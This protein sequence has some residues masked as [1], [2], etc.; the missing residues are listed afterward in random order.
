[1]N[2]KGQSF[3]A[4]AATLMAS[5]LVVKIIGMLFKIPLT[6]MLGGEGMGYYMTAYSIF[7]PIYAL[8]VA[9]FPVAVS[10]L[11]ASSLARHRNDEPHR[12]LTVALFLFLPIGLG[13]AAAIYFAAPLFVKIVGNEAAIA[14]VRSIA[15]AVF[16]CCIS[17]VFRGYY[18]GSRNMVPTAVS[19]VV[20]ASVKLGAGIFCA[21]RTLRV[22]LAHFAAG[23][24]VCG[25]IV[26]SLQDAQTVIAPYAAAAAISGVTIST[27]A[28]SAVLALCY[29]GEPQG[30]AT[31]MVEHSAPH[32]AK[33][34]LVT[35]LPVCAGAL[36]VNLSSLIDLMSV[37]N[38]L[39]LAVVRGWETICLS[40]P[41]AGLEGMEAERIGNFLFG[42]YSGLAMTIF[43]LVPAL[44]ASFGVCALPLIASLA[45]RGNR[46]A[47]RRTV[48]SVLRITVLVALP[49]GFG[50]SCMAGPILELLFSSNPE[51]ISVA[52]G[53]LRP[54]G[55]AA[56]FVAISGCVNSML[57]ALG[58]VMVPVRLMLCGAAVKLAVNWVLI[59]QPGI[60]ISGAPWGT[61]CCYLLMALMGCSALERA[62]EGQ[63]NLV[64]IFAK[65]L[66][67]TLL[68][69]ATALMTR[70]FLAFLDPRLCTLLAAAAAG[71]CYLAA[72]LL[73]GALREEDM[74]LLPKGIKIR[75]ER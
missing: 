33:S 18:E 2:R 53:L 66:L 63:L 44:T 30:K 51:E 38:R 17:A 9:G 47:L 73:L 36:V 31:Q 26:T 34:L 54:L 75:K 52:V 8:C 23:E 62:T 61:L 45:A 67:S 59:A 56:V 32:Y 74:E 37:I 40:H 49:L 58:W 7:N 68:C 15:P 70:R 48:D 27:L 57:Q 14:A 16:F 5:A 50:M 22:Q 71:L 3:A 42:S 21:M 35:A 4:G 13:C 65:P 28:G 6:R 20:E 12:I 69:C 24:P 29:A 43:H 39:N 55:V 41:Q 25:V 60:N 72:I 11:T 46:A 10:R 19:Q 1:M 64:S